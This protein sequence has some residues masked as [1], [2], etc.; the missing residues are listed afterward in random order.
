VESKL[1][2]SKRVPSPADLEEQLGKNFVAGGGPRALKLALVGGQYRDA[3]LAGHCTLTQALVLYV[4]LMR[5]CWNESD[6]GDGTL[7]RSFT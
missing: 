4:N 7:E 1:G 2:R 6:E 3:D 5:C